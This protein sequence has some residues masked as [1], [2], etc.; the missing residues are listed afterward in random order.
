MKTKNA[1]EQFNALHNTLATKKKLIALKK[2]AINQLQQNVVQRLAGLIID[3]PFSLFGDKGI[4][5]MIKPKATWEATGTALGAPQN[6]KNKT[7]SATKEINSLKSKRNKTKKGSRRRNIIVAEINKK[8]AL[9][10]KDSKGITIGV[11]PT[12]KNKDTAG[13]NGAD[14]NSLCGLEFLPDTEPVNG[15]GK[16]VSPDDIYQYVTD[17]IINTIK[18][19]ANLPW[20]KSWSKSGLSDGKEATNY[21]S[22]KGYRGINF[23]LL[24]FEVKTDK[25][26]DGYL[27]MINWKNPFF[28]T[29]KQ[30]Q[31]YKGKLKKGAKGHRVVYF[32]K[33]YGH[34]ETLDNGNK[35]EF[36]TYS[37]PKFLSWIK[38]HQYQLKII[39]RSGWSVERLANTYIPILKYYNVFNA[40][41]ITGIKWD[42]IPVNE[43][44]NKSPNDKIA[45]AESII[46]NYP[47]P[48]KIMFAG[49]QP[50]YNISKDTVVQTP[51]VDFKDPQNYYSVLFHE[52]IHSTGAKKRL[53]RP[54]GQSMKDPK[55]A[56]EELVAEMGAVFLCAES[57]ILFKTLNNSAAYLKSWN[58]KLVSHMK[59]DNRFFFRASSAAQ[60]ATDHILDRNKSGVPKYVRS[61]TKTKKNVPSS[62]KTAT[63]KTRSVQ[64]PNKVEIGYRI[65]RKI[66][67]GGGQISGTE[68][69]VYEVSTSGKSFRL[70]DTHG[71]KSAKWYQTSNFKPNEIFAPRKRA[72]GKS[73]R[74]SS[75][76]NGHNKFIEKT[77]PRN[78]G[79]GKTIVLYNG[80]PIVTV[81]KPAEFL[82]DNSAMVLE[83]ANVDPTTPKVKVPAANKK[84]G[85]LSSNDLMAMH[86]DTLPFT[87]KWE[88]F[89]QNPAKNMK[90]AFFGKP[91]NG[92]TVGACQFANMLTNFG[93]VLYNF[94]DQGINKSTQDIWR[95]TGLQSN[96][97]AF[98]TDTR[99]LIELEK[100]CAT[101]DYDFVF[102]DLI[103][104]YIKR[105]KLKPVEFEDRFIKAFPDISFVYIMESTKSGDFRGDNDWMHLPDAI[106]DVADF[107]MNNNGRYGMGEYIVWADGLKKKNPK[108]YK[109][110]VLDNE[111]S[112]EE[113]L[114]EEMQIPMGE[115]IVL[116]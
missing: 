114:E 15:L 8:E 96:S 39:K 115:A 69:I 107:V 68:G 86:F 57:G 9:L 33:L 104:T 110:L 31:K 116:R 103:N 49:D 34:S 28:L 24:N 45:I 64:K 66:N 65:K 77:T 5:I 36:Y 7:L 61:V 81:P 60:A 29:F 46:V 91:K 83:T 27:S 30:I 94:A 32:T 10:I 88:V 70:K 71:N 108:L 90:I 3:Y 89:M 102:I 87:G 14:I 12:P 11:K 21:E 4:N 82:G 92:K 6:Q 67:N 25:N 20:Q 17:L 101:G 59:D 50:H 38:R 76:S 1:V 19:T 52:L 72:K 37:K 13:L 35:L 18:K 97:G 63:Q 58:G 100:L 2:L 93:N 16:P 85:V 42:K 62:R 106:V 105:D 74:K 40:Q 113:K 111:E 73:L 23:F 112:P 47:N 99:S 55:Y 56:K 41:D 54:F 51:I 98:L 78:K 22:K 80:K 44:A 79:L 75:L 26:G 53:D 109:Q 84:N 95:L 48:P 43:N